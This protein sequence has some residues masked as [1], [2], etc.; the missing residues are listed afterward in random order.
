MSEAEPNDTTA[1]EHWS[2]LLLLAVVSFLFVWVAWPFAGPLLWSALAAIMFQPLY[3]WSLRQMRGKRNLAASLTLFIIF[4]VVL[5]PALWIGSLVVDDAV[6]LVNSLR[7]NPI[8]LA[9]WFDEALAILPSSNEHLEQWIQENVQGL[10]GESAGMLAQQAFAIG[11]GALGFV[12]SFGL[13]LYVLYFLLR[14]GT[15]IGETILHSAPIEREIADRLAERFVRPMVIDRICSLVEPA[16]K[17][18][19]NKGLFTKEIEEALGVVKDREH[20]SE[21]YQQEQAQESKIKLG[22][23]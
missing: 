4:V 13:G 1:L 10:L 23:D 19:G 15:R 9:Q 20:T 5:L 22:G 12:L 3:K 8:D 2:F 6:K 11:G 18:I 17:E 21:F 16:M 7:E 14:D